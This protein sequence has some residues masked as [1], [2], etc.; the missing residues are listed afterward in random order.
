[1][2]DCATRLISGQFSTYSVLHPWESPETAFLHGRGYCSQYNGALAIILQELGF[3]AWLVYATRVRFDDHQ[4]WALGHTWVQVR[5]DGEVRDACARSVEN[6][7][8][9]VHF[10]PIHRVRM[11]NRPMRFLTTLGSYGTAVVAIV[12]ARLLGQ[13]RPEW[14]EHP[15]GRP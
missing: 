1:M 3:Q 15:R 11:L 6:R 4:D 13:P 9:Y 10:T 12:G 8:G 2:V 5:V 14:V 7:A